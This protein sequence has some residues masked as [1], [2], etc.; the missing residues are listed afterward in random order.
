MITE[1]QINVLITV[2]N[3]IQCCEEMHD[4]DAARTW[5]ERDQPDQSYG[6]TCFDCRFAF[7]A[8][9]L[10]SASRTTENPIVEVTAIYLKSI[11]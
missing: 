10:F 3:F 4:D 2:F 5:L 7:M 1:P 11:N 6:A 9:P 8:S